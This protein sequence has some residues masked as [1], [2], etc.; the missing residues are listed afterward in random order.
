M[1]ALSRA[2]LAFSVVQFAPVYAYRFP[3]LTT[4][5]PYVRPFTARA[6]TSSMFYALL[7]YRCPG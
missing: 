2:A 7:A 6:T 4:L 1:L 3:M 5:L